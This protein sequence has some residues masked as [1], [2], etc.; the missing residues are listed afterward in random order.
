MVGAWC[1]SHAAWRARA[2]PTAMDGADVLPSV[3]R[4]VA[5][6]FRA[7]PPALQIRAA[8]GIADPPA[9]GDG[10][11]SHL[12]GCLFDAPFGRDESSRAPAQWWPR[13]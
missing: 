9:G 3:L 6:L 12:R 7:C 4:L 13:W 8:Q 10:F 1:H 5:S 11:T 2:R